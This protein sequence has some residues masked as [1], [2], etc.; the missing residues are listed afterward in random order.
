MPTIQSNSAGQSA[1]K[2]PFYWKECMPW[3]LLSPFVGLCIGTAVFN[4]TMPPLK[5]S[6][7]V[8]TSWGD[9]VGKALLQQEIARLQMPHIWKIRLCAWLAI[10][11]TLLVCAAYVQWTIWRRRRELAAN[12]AS[13]DDVE[14]YSRLLDRQEP[15]MWLLRAFAAVKSL[16]TPEGQRRLADGLVAFFTF[17]LLLVEVLAPLLLVVALL[18]ST[19]KGIDRCSEVIVQRGLLGLVAS[20]AYFITQTVVCRVSME[21]FMVPFSIQGVLR[22]IRDRFAA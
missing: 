14:A 22:S 17:R 13:V 20:L 8:P 10:P 1:A 15:R 11:V 7:T 21:C 9:V 16:C 2:P 12:P 3:L 6:V 5:A 4:A 19:S 18:L